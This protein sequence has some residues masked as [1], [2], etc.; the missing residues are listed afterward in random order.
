MFSAMLEVNP[1]PAQFDAY[2]GMAKMLRPEL[3]KIDGFIDNNRYAS[4]TRE[5]WLLSLSSWRD[6][7]ALIRW[8]SQE[9]HHKIMQAARDRVFAD[10]RLRIGQVVSDNQLPEGQVLREQRLDVTEVGQ[11]TAVTLHDGRFAPEWVKE[12]GAQNVAKALGVDT[13]AVGLVSWDV[14]DAL[15]APGDVIAVLTWQ[16][17]AAAEAYLRAAEH[18][19]STRQR[20]VRIVREYGMFDR[21]EAPQFFK[22]AEAKA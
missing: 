3:E 15:M 13:S 22:A 10:Y 19:D 2:L 6:E 5:G 4:L 21:R 20:N 17:H 9:T 1:I 12:T 14:F 18:A 8:R 11:G 7:K 16:D